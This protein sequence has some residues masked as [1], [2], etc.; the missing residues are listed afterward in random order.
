MPSYPILTITSCKELLSHPETAGALLRERLSEAVVKC[1]SAKP[2]KLISGSF[3]DEALRGHLSNRLFEAEIIDSKTA[4][5]YVLIEHKST[6]D[7]KVG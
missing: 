1:L 4:F 5:L 3:V 6:P 2:P 7:H